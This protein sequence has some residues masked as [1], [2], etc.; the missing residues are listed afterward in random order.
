MYNSV[1]TLFLIALIREHWRSSELVLLGLA[2]SLCWLGFEF[3]N[4]RDFRIFR[5]FLHFW[6]ISSVDLGFI[7]CCKFAVNCLVFGFSQKYFIYG[8]VFASCFFVSFW[9][10]I[11]VLYGLV[12]ASCFFVVVRVEMIVADAVWIY[13]LGEFSLERGFHMQGPQFWVI[14][15]FKNIWWG[16]SQSI[17][18]VLLL[19]SVHIFIIWVYRC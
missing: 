11:E 14:M 19:Q 4:W 7:V 6:V 18:F 13:F 2:S 16:N 12:F 10:F 8:L 9:V 15:M 17:L 5:R 3:F 1:E